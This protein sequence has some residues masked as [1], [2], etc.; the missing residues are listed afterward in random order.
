MKVIFIGG[1][2]NG[3]IVYDYLKSNKF[4]ELV[5]T[6]TYKDDYQG[7]RFVTF[8]NSENIIKS[9]TVKG[10]ERKIVDLKPDVIFVA[11]W[12]ELIPNEILKIP[13]MGVIGFHP[14]KLPNDRGRSVLAWQIEDGYTETA[15]TMFKY[16]D[17]PD[18]GNILAQ[19]M[20]KIEE[21]D[22]INDILDKIDGATYNIMKAYFPLFRQ[23]LI[24]EKIQDLSEG[25]FRRLRGVKDS[26]IN[27]NETV[28]NIYNK[29]RAISKPYPGA[30][31]ELEGK[32]IM[33]WR[34]YKMY[35]FPF[36]K[37][38][39]NG[40]LVCKL[41]DGSLIVKCSDGY[42]RITEYEEK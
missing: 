20:I 32:E 11:G 37:E 5:Q 29:I 33:V 35:E 8:D 25:N 22:Y 7:A 17:Y 36:G 18:G 42:I 15:L 1:L 41:Y 27:W 24:K 39:D 34:A 12:S 3:K 23:N 30:T 9:G 10:Y 19:E 14:A 40:K 16:S 28:L 4:V 13:P 2:T 31:T 6:I 38:L 21:K 26:I